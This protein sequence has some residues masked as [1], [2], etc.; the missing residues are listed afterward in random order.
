M[1]DEPSRGLV[2]TNV[3]ILRRHLAAEVLPEELAIS[4]VTLAEL[5]AG[6][7]LVQGEGAE[8]ARERAARLDLLA[9]V[10]REF[11]PFEFGVDA[12]RLFGRLSAAVVALG[13]SPRRR[14][15]DLMIAATAGAQ[16][17]PLYTT[18]PD[19]FGGL[20]GL[21]EVVAIERPEVAAD[22]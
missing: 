19:D 13:R 6:V 22:R 4:A 9:R 14:V 8:A 1:S 16:G 20:D 7:H 12:A 11:D 3:L 5:S 10:E 2:D 15:A 17:L 18:N 21:V